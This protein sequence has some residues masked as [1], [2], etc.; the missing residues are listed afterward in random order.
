MD[1]HEKTIAPPKN[2][3]KMISCDSKGSIQMMLFGSKGNPVTR[4][5]NAATS[6]HTT[7]KPSREIHNI[8]P[9][10]VL[11]HQVNTLLSPW[12]KISHVTSPSHL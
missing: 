8:P 3:E 4:N 12:K 6:E 11:A 2:K 5:K 9:Q 10:V 1:N 7:L